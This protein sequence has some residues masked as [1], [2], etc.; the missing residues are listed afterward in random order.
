MV[1]SVSHDIGR[2]GLRR[3][4]LSGCWGAHAPG[5]DDAPDLSM[6][7]HVRRPAAATRHVDRSVSD[8]TRAALERAGL[9]ARID[10]HDVGE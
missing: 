2:E 6:V 8:V 1:M 5:P 3:E 7:V 4:H 9:R 10:G